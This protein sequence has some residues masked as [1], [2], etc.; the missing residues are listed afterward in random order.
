MVVKRISKSAVRELRTVLRTTDMVVPEDYT[1]TCR[2]LWEIDVARVMKEDFIQK[3]KDHTKYVWLPKMATC[4][5]GS[6]GSLL[7]SSFCEHIN[8]CANQVLTLRN[9][10]LSDVEMEKSVMCH[11]NQDF[12]TSMRKHYPNVAKEQFEFGTVLTE[13]E[14]GGGKEE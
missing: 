8:S 9:S 12:I 10:L 11:M 1:L 7:A 4:S 3:D 6:I 2:D 14:T 5:K 13:E